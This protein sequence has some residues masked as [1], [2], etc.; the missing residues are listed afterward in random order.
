VVGC[1][2]Q[3]NGL[4]LPGM[5]SAVAGFS[6]EGLG[7]LILETAGSNPILGPKFGGLTV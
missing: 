7:L 6:F 4:F 3:G 5:A 2:A 1:S